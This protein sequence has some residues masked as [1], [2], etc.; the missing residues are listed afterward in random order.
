MVLFLQ[1]LSGFGQERKDVIRA[2]AACDDD[3]ANRFDTVLVHETNDASE[4]G[5]E[6]AWLI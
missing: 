2:S 5:V 3:K 6:G 4:V 1:P